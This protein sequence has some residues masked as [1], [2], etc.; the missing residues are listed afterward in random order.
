MLEIMIPLF[1]QSIKYN[2]IQSQKRNTFLPFFIEYLNR[3]VMIL[4][5][6]FKTDS[7][8]KTNWCLY[9]VYNESVKILH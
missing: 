9:F 6:I 4:I 3:L 5:F 8:S 2:L 1:N 7:Q